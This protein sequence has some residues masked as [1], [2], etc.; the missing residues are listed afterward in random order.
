MKENCVSTPTPA[1]PTRKIDQIQ[2]PFLIKYIIISGVINIARIK[3]KAYN[4]REAST[5]TIYNK[6][7]G[8]GYS[9]DRQNTI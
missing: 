6:F 7:V 2:Q 5:E 9:I 8:K 1:K 3:K 4:L